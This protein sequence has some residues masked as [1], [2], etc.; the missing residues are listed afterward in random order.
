MAPAMSRDVPNPN[1]VMAL[2]TLLRLRIPDEWEDINGHVNVQYYMALYDRAGHAMLQQL[3]L[4][5]SYFGDRRLGVFDAEHHVRYLAE[6]H[7]GDEVSAH[8][9]YVGRSAT[10]VLGLFILVNRSRARIASI[11]EFLSVSVDLQTR[12]TTAFPAFLAANI[13][14]LIAS[15]SALDWTAP[16]SG[17]LQARLGE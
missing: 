17:A 14:N 1:Q 10:R 12:R 13:D 3:G 2:P 6:I 8:A 15:D 5:E 7:V 4:D 11:L 16:L 9:R